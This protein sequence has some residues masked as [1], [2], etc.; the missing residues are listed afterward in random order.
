VVANR[1]RLTNSI[2]NAS[3]ARQAITVEIGATYRFVGTAFAGPVRSGQIRVGSAAG[4]NDLHNG[5]LNTTSDVQFVA[6]TAEAHISAV[7][8]GTGAGNYVEFDN[9]SLTKVGP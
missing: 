2:I 1:L 7:V 5:A 6:T 9:I 4:L 3:Q 8:A